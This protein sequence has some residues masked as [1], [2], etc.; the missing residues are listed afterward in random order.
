MKASTT[1]RTSPWAGEGICLADQKLSVVWKTFLDD[2]EMPVMFLKFS[3]GMEDSIREIELS[4][5]DDVIDMLAEL[6]FAAR[7]GQSNDYGMS[8][9]Y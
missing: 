3:I 8:D 9:G 4:H 2:I 6:S 5:D 1:Y 7:E